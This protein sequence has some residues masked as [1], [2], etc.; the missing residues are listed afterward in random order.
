MILSKLI[1]I[2]AAILI[3]MAATKTFEMLF[4]ISGIAAL[5]GYIHIRYSDAMERRFISVS[6]ISGATL[7]IIAILIYYYFFL[8]P[9]N[10]DILGPDGESYQARGW[11]ISRIANDIDPR[12]IPS[13][14]QIFQSYPDMVEY[15]KSTLPGWKLHQVGIFSYLIGLIYFLFGYVP[16]LIKFSNGLI[17]AFTAVLVYELARELF[18]VRVARAS[19]LAVMFLPSMFIFSLT[20]MK[21][22]SVIMCL[23]LI[24]L[25]IVKYRR[26]KKLFFIF[27]LVVSA[28]PIFLIKISMVLPVTLFIAVSSFALIK[29]RWKI[30]ILFC[31]LAIVSSSAYKQRM[32]GYI[33]LAALTNPHIG[34]VNTPG[35]N[36]KIFPDEYYSRAKDIAKIKP[37]EL[38]IAYAKGTVHALFEPFPAKANSKGEIFGMLQTLPWLLFFPFVLFGIAKSLRCRDKRRYEQRIVLLIFLIICLSFL[39]ITGGNKGTVFRHRDMLMPFLIILGMVGLCRNPLKENS[40]VD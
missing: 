22:S 24:V 8:L 6:F 17:S 39:S 25:S 29:S 14:E 10:T 26:S 9:G 30:I 12:V 34:F 1:L 13:S 7:R 38:V 37:F 27:L 35:N 20:A 16:L 4:A 32:S 3:G 18:T 28:V 36:Y 2:F 33:N 11:Y 21:D 19:L 5:Y 15:Y 31:L 23:V 40:F